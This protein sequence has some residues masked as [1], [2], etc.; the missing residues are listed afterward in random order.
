MNKLANIL[1]KHKKHIVETPKRI[2]SIL[3]PTR[4]ISPTQKKHIVET[5]KRIVSILGPPRTIWPTHK[6]HIVETP[7]RI[8]ST[9][10]PIRIIWAHTKK[11]QIMIIKQVLVGFKDLRF[12]VFIHVQL[13]HFISCNLINNIIKSN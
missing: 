12:S 10:G 8:V 9:L 13:V 3:V 7:K 4:I 2:V 6:K 11:T 5:P 1:L